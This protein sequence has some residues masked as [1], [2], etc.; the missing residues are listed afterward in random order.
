VVVLSY[1]EF[2]VFIPMDQERLCGIV[3][4]P[5][6]EAR[7]LGVVLLTGGNYTRTHRNGMWV[8]AAREL[9]VRGFA[10]IRLDYHGVGESTGEASFDLE[11]PFDDDVIAA[12]EFLR[13]AAGVDQLILVA[14]CFGG[15]TAMAAAARYEAA[16]AVTIFPVDLKVDGDEGAGT[17]ATKG[18]SMRSRVGR[19]IR[20]RTLGRK[21]LRRP[22]ARRL[23]ASNAAKRDRGARISP[24][25]KRQLTTYLQRSGTRIWMMY[26]DQTESLPDME[27]CLAELDPRLTPEQRARIHLDITQGTEMHRFQSLRDQ[28]I[29]VERAVWSV[30]QAYMSMLGSQP[31]G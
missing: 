26:G 9:A 1:E 15:R 21:L 23:R 25:F 2:P 19:V 12:G 20:G 29:V 7:D 27:R 13:R 28:D 30:E 31:V 8:R 24:A 11:I 22:T 10:S 18:R 17:P 5:R 3:C 16:D 14:T 4:S 6:G